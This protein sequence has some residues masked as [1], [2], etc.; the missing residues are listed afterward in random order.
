MRK[1]PKKSSEVAS[2]EVLKGYLK[3]QTIEKSEGETKISATNNVYTR[4]FSFQPIVSLVQ[5]II[6]TIYNKTIIEFGFSW[7]RE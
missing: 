6:S 2:E 4:L 3:T 7:Y 5:K 1:I